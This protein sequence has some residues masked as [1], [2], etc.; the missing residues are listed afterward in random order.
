[1]DDNRAVALTDILQNKSTV[2]PNYSMKAAIRDLV[3]YYNAGTLVRAFAELSKATGA[4]ALASQAQVRHF[5]GPFTKSSIPSLGLARVEVEVDRQKQSLARQI[6]NAEAATPLPAAPV[7]A[8]ALARRTAALQ[9]VRVKLEAIW[10]NIL[11]NNKFNAAVTAL[12]ADP[13]KAAVLTRIETA[14]ANVTEREYLTSLFWLQAVLNKDLDL[15][16][17]LLDVLM[18]TNS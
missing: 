2:A 17:E 6:M 11:S 1:M 5:K 16:R 8:A 13:A 12:K 7:P 3:E 10:R 4:Q 14:P 18:T 15:N 9:P